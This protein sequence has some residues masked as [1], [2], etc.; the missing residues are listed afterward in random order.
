MFTPSVV[1]STQRPGVSTTFAL[2]TGGQFARGD[3]HRGKAIELSNYPTNAPRTG[4]GPRFR[5]RMAQSM[6]SLVICV[7]H[8]EECW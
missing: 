2:G 7:R 4:G 1:M 3:Y 6:Y 5:L 8:D